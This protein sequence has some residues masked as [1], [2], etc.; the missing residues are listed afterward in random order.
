VLANIGDLAYMNV[1]LTETATG[2]HPQIAIVGAGWNPFPSVHY[3]IRHNGTQ[4]LI[5]PATQ[6][7]ISQVS[8]VTDRRLL[9]SI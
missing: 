3:P 6:G 9:I 2:K 4:L 7:I 5:P 1:E 8:N